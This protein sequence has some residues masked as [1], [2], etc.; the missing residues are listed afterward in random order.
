M[1]KILLS[2][3]VVSSLFGSIFGSKVYVKSKYGFSYTKT[4]ISRSNDCYAIKGMDMQVC[5]RRGKVKKE[6]IE[7]E[8]KNS[9]NE[10]L[11]IRDIGK[12]K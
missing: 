12:S 2:L 8:I 3:I 1:K 7:K 9:I 4:N 11:M 5:F 10:E 6:D